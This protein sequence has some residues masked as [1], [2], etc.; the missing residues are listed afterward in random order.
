MSGM[1]IMGYLL[2]H[3][4]C[5]IIQIWLNQANGS[6]MCWGS[7]ATN[8]FACGHPFFANILEAAHLFGGEDPNFLDMLGGFFK[9]V[10]AVLTGFVKLAFVDYAWMHGG[11]QITDMVALIVKLGMGGIF[12]G[13]IGKVVFTNIIGRR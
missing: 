9:V 7:A 4:V 3:V 2:V 6:E 5:W 10:W 12:F 13:I 8:P 1:I 11:G